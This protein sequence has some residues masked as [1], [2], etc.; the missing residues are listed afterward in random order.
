MERAD[1]R[2]SGLRIKVFAD[3]A[4]LEGILELAA[5]PRDQ[6]IYHQ[7]DAHAQGGYRGL[8]GVRP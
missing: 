8:R 2:G 4:D 6:R 3:G 7:P 5:D 1:A